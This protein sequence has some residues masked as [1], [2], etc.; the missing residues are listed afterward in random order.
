MHRFGLDAA[1]CQKGYLCNPRYPFHPRFKTFSMAGSRR[2]ALGF[3]RL[4]NVLGG[5]G[6][7]ARLAHRV[8]S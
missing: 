3:L 5:F 1:V 8:H 4:D 6:E 2:F 7:K